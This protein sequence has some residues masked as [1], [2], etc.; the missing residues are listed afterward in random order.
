MTPTVPLA[1]INV[2]KLRSDALE[3]SNL[4]TNKPVTLQ[5]R[6]VIA[7]IINREYPT[8]PKQTHPLLDIMRDD[9]EVWSIP[10]YTALVGWLAPYSL[11]STYPSAI[12]RIARYLLG[13]TKEQE[14]SKVDWAAVYQHFP[15][16]RPE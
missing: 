16:L 6:I 2:T 11:V 12:I 4:K 15:Q 3:Q 1:M 7:V 9:L 8:A 10:K 13:E 5:E 14:E